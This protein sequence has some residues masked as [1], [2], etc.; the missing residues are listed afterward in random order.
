MTNF[1]FLQAQW[2]DVF[3]SALKA[4]EN[5]YNDPRIS[6]FY[7]RL[8]LE[9]AVKWLYKN[10]PYL[11]LPY[12]DN[13]SA[14]IHEQTFRDNLDPQIFPKI[15]TIQKVGNIAAHSDRKLTATDSVHV[16]KELFHFLFWVYRFYSQQTPD[17]SIAFNLEI[18]SQNTVKEKQTTQDDLSKLAESL[19]AKDKE[20]SLKEQRLAQTEEELKKLKQRI[21]ELKERNK[22]VADNHDYTE[23]ETRSYFIDLLLQEVGWDLSL[24]NVIEYPVAG[25][26]NN[27]GKGFVDYVLW[28]NDGLPLAVVEAKRTKVNVE[29]G[30]HQAKLYAD[31]LEKMHGQR[32]IIFYTNGYEHYLWDDLNYPPRAV[33]GF[34]KKDELQLLINRRNQRQGLSNVSINKDIVNRYYQERAV[35]KVAEN[36]QKRS[37]KALLVMA[38]GTGKT[39]TAIALVDILQKCGWAK[40]ILFL[41]DRVALLNQAKNAF[42]K[43]L[44]HTSIVDISQDKDDTTARIVLS[45]YPTMMNSIDETKN[46]EKR[47]SVGHFD[48]IIV[49]E[50]HR[51]IYLKYKAIFEYF[52]ALMIGL[53]A[54]PRS[55]VDR[56]TYDMF[57]LEKGVPTDY[58]ELEQA[59][60]DDYLV[61]LK[62]FSVPMKL[63]EEGV[64]YNELTE[65]EKEHYEFLFTNEDTEEMPEWIYPSALNSWLFND[66]TVDQVLQYL[67]ENGLRIEGG[68]RLGK[69]IIFAKNHNHA[70]FI[71]ERFDKLYPQYHG[72]FT[73]VIDNKVNYAQS[74]IDD[75]SILNKQPTIA[76]SVD[77]LDTGIDVPEILNLV[78]FKIVR[79][80]VKFHQMIGRGTRLCENLFGPNEHKQ[81]FLIFDFCNNFAFFNENPE[82]FIS[83]NQIPLTQ[84]V[85]N[86]KLSL[87][88]QTKSS[89]ID[90]SKS[91]LQDLFYEISQMDLDNF[92][93]RAKRKHVEKYSE[94]KIWMNLTEADI[95]DIQKNVTGL[96][97]PL[98]HDSE[99]AKR[100]DIMVLSTEEAL[101]A[102]S[103]SLEKLISQLKFIANKLESKSSIPVI[104]EQLAFILEMQ[105]DSFW[106]NITLYILE[107]I[108]KKLRDLVQFLEIDEGQKIIYSSF[109]D[110]IGEASEV[111]IDQFATAV[112]MQQYK[113]KVEQY[114]KEHTEH[115][116]IYKLMHNQPITEEDVRLLEDFLFNSEAIGDKNRFSEVF[117][118]EEP[119]GAFIRKIVGLDRGSAMEAFGEFLNNKNFSANQIH[120]LETIVDYLTQNGLMDVKALY[121]SPFTDFHD[122]GLDGLFDNDTTESLITIIYHI[123][124]NALVA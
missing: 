36:Y 25:M 54:T 111:V 77:M 80:K 62:A 84:K 100:F 21:K 110:E 44:P 114:I 119:L 102:K 45:T 15:R 20:M 4:E 31:C 6:C 72:H 26:P 112:D 30:R 47:F 14:L 50:A 68:D 92:Q 2:P 121:E 91:F 41:A 113:K 59:V 61:P 23:A 79:S 82:G 40:R 99:I 58:Y 8:S 28:G 103:K 43:H 71:K 124:E 29:T 1:N 39:R 106:E 60:A 90:Y 16:L 122:H 27:D 9:R 94:E 34:Y 53:T 67:M 63:P 13:L 52:D 12:D 22:K 78:F 115:P 65:E 105:A 69:T 24:P 38:T 101:I 107:D 95:A 120:F 49:D 108:R 73:Q 97:S 66:N 17:T 76:I 46:K 93:V 74:L 3:E 88:I 42:K 104:K 33:Q 48:L 55:E 96:P 51:S 37:R 64:K 75:F 109:T 18:I 123:R 35:R 5:V 87:A 116:S 70:E 118:K 98:T 85:L 7:S 10:E 81:F 117:G 19:Q 56:N 86:K 89:A 32:P 11:Q 83:G 57:E